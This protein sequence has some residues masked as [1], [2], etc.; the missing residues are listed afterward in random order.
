[1]VYSSIEMLAGSLA[2]IS[3]SFSLRRRREVYVGQ[4]VLS[5]LKKAP[6]FRRSKNARR[7]KLRR[8]AIA[9]M[10]F[11]EAAKASVRLQLEILDRC[12]SR[13]LAGF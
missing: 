9:N 6:V 1:M 12:G 11:V 5:C 4:K 3:Y 13:V 7:S 10:K 8:M 2:V